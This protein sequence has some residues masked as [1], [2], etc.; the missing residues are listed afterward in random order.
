[1]GESG[2]PENQ[3]VCH[4]NNV[5]ISTQKFSPKWFLEKEL[6]RKRTIDML[7][8]QASTFPCD[9]RNTA[10]QRTSPWRKAHKLAIQYQTVIFKNLQISDNIQT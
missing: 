9:Q 8:G 7:S 2:K 1:M 5:R 4:D 6:N 3:R 10:S